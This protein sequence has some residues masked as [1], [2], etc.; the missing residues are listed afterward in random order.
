VNLIS[1]GW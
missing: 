1:L